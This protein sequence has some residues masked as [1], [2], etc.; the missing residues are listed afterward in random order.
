MIPAAFIEIAGDILGDTDKGLT[1]SEITSKLS[2][3]GFDFDVDVPFQTYPF[4]AHKKVPNKRF[5]LKR[6]LEAFSPEQQFKIIKD[7]CELDRFKGNSAV[8]DLKLKLITRFGHLNSEIDSVNEILIDETIHWLH[9]YSESLSVYES[10]LE[11]FRNNRRS[12][13]ITG[14]TH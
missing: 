11:K 1:G 7:L 5:A 10:A 9:D 6:N 4:P 3:Y 8:K 12:E 13:I 14:I 2:V